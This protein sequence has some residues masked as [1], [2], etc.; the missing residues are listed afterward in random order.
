MKQLQIFEAY[1]ALMKLSEQDLPIKEAWAVSKLMDTLRPC[2]E[3]QMAEERK[4]LDKCRWTNTADGIQF[5]KSED[6]EAFRQKMDEIMDFEHDVEVKPFKLKLT[7]DIKLSPH[8]IK[9]LEPFIE[10]TEAA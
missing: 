5:E 10:F 2:W 1:K 7:D 6:A 4:Q 9:A 8:D 3:F